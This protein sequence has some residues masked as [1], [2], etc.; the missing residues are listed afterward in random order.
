MKKSSSVKSIRR[1]LMEK[2]LMVHSDRSTSANQA[3][4]S[5]FMGNVLAAVYCWN[6]LLFHSFLAIFY[7][8]ILMKAAE[9]RVSELPPNLGCIL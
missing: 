5:Y 6:P 4:S 2:S 7:V 1:V 3:I 8:V 9:L